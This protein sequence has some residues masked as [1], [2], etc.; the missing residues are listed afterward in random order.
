MKE[1]TKKLIIICII[2][3]IIIIC[4]LLAIKLKIFIYR[5]NSNQIMGIDVNENTPSLKYTNISNLYIFSGDEINQIEIAKE[6]E[7]I[8]ENEIPKI[9]EN[10]KSFDEIQIR[11]YYNQNIDNIEN[12]FFSID[13]ENFLK[14]VLKLK[15]MKCNLN[16]DYQICDFKLEDDNLSVNIICSYNDGEKIIL[17]LSKEMKLN[18]VE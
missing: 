11:E 6:F 10:T 2:I 1:K 14:L 16:H 8:F 17:N 13:E 15:T 3:L 12:T 5:K 18:I 7:N 4:M 9:F